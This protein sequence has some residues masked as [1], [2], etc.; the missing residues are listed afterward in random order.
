MRRGAAQLICVSALAASACA[1]LASW[2]Y[3]WAVEVSMMC[4]AEVTPNSYHQDSASLAP[5]VA[6]A[7]YNDAYNNAYNVLS[8]SSAL[9]HTAAQA[10][11]SAP[12]PAWQHRCRQQGHVAS[13]PR[14]D[15]PGCKPGKRS[16]GNGCTAGPWQCSSMRSEEELQPA[17]KHHCRWELVESSPLAADRPALFGPDGSTGASTCSQ[18][19]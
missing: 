8:S 10:D 17:G 3:L 16:I 5:D 19:R 6:A 14:L 11:C 4:S 2:T 13:C 7:A 15:G 9:D 12:A 1:A 18:Q